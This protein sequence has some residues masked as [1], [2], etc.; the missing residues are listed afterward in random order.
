MGLIRLIF[1]Y[2]GHYS[3]EYQV[4]SLVK[5]LPFSKPSC[6]VEDRRTWRR[7]CPKGTPLSQKEVF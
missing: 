3:M 1:M 2:W 5:V 6:L 4:Y 7:R